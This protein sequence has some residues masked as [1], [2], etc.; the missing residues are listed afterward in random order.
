MP[1]S[2]SENN[3]PTTIRFNITDNPTPY[4][5]SDF[6]EMHDW[7]LDLVDRAKQIKSAFSNEN[8]QLALSFAA[9]LVRAHQELVDAIEPYSSLEGVKFEELEQDEIAEALETIAQSAGD[10][11]AGNVPIIDG[12]VGRM[13]YETYPENA[14]IALGLGLVHTNV[15]EIN[16]FRLQQLPW[17]YLRNAVLAEQKLIDPDK[18]AASFSNKANELQFQN[19]HLQLTL[20]QR[21]DS[22]DEKLAKMIKDSEKSYEAAKQKF[23]DFMVECMHERKQHNDEVDAL[24][25]AY[26]VHMSLEAPAKYWQKKCK[27][28]SIG[29]WVSLTAFSLLVICSLTTIWLYGPA[30]VKEVTAGTQGFSLPAFAMITIPALFIAW[31]MKIFANQIASNHHLKQD[32]ALRQTMITTF[33]ALMK[34]PGNQVGVEERT[35]I[36]NAIFRPADRHT[37]DNGPSAGLIELVRQAKS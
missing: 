22:L 9:N 34:D 1:K 20:R 37:D 27:G 21:H 6:D 10:I 25:Q 18:L 24:K 29:F 28:H 35:L 17:K 7:A 13:I 33:L 4:V 15:T 2:K 19:E 8:H 3:R 12:T 11:S 16:Q 36:L 32:S 14:E 26:E 31:V 5:F 30:F 23:K